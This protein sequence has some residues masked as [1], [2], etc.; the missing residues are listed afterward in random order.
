MASKK[1]DF[2][3]ES[4]VEEY[5]RDTLKVRASSAGVDEFGKRFNGIMA[6]VL[7]EAARLS[8]KARRKTVMPEDLV[9]AFAKHVGKETLDWDEVA[10][11]LMKLPAADLGKISQMITKELKRLGG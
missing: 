5:I 10:A 11:H 2:V 8:K 9:A 4:A 1:V 3:K 7:K 6:T